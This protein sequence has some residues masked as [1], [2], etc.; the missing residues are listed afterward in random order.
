MPQ[1]LEGVVQIDSGML[2]PEDADR[3]QGQTKNES[4]FGVLSVKEV[5]SLP[6]ALRDGTNGDHQQ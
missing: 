4:C 6:D 3:R 5:V 2:H 1:G